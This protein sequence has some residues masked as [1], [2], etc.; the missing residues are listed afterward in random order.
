M[1]ATVIYIGEVVRAKTDDPTL[2]LYILN[3]FSE[4]QEELEEE[5][6]MNHKSIQNLGLSIL[7][8]KTERQCSLSRLS[9]FGFLLKYIL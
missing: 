7:D 6:N 1:A 3:G 4:M 5:L 2:A 8:C 9:A